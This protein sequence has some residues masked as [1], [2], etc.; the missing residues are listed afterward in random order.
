MKSVIRTEYLPK[1]QKPDVC[2]FCKAKEI[3][4]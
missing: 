1:E 2:R 4:Q 3:K